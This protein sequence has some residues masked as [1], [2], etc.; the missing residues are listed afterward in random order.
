[1][2]VMPDGTIM[3]LSANKTMSEKRLRELVESLIEI[4]LAGD[5]ATGPGM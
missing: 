1:M 4:K 5:E 2:I 3:S